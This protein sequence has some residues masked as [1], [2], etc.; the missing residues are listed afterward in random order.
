MEL[1]IEQIKAVIKAAK[2]LEQKKDKEISELVEVFLGKVFEQT[3]IKNLKALEKI[4]ALYDSYKENDWFKQ[5]LEKVLLEGQF[6]YYVSER[7]IIKE[8]PTTP[9]VYPS[10]PNIWNGDK[11]T[12][13]PEPRFAVYCSSSNNTS[14]KEI[15]D[16]IK[17]M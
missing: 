12:N 14:F 15:E 3:K 7:T 8:V 11:L 2:K 4:I 5:G 1:S 17:E 13:I 10:W 16:F 9:I 6:P